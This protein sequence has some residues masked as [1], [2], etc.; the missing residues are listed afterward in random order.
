MAIRIFGIFG[1]DLTVH[2]PEVIKR[3]GIGSL[4]NLG[5]WPITPQKGQGSVIKASPAINCT[6][7][8]TLYVEFPEKSK[9]KIEKALY[10]VNLSYPIRKHAVKPWSISKEI[11][12][13]D[14]LQ[15]NKRV[16]VEGV[17]QKNFME[18]NNGFRTHNQSL[19]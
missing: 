18:M 9:S 10:L 2:H 15:K 14:L 1:Q 8:A 17:E 6:K 13:S 19:L 12:K 3:Q 4:P 5:Y 16:F 7:T 11:S